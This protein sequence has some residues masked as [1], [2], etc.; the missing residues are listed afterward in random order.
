MT[1]RSTLDS[2]QLSG[3]PRRKSFRADQFVWWVT[4]PEHTEGPRN[5]IGIIAKKWT[6]SNGLTK[7]TRP[8]SSAEKKDKQCDRLHGMSTHRHYQTS[9]L[10]DHPS[11]THSS[12]FRVLLELKQ[13]GAPQWQAENVFFRKFFLYFCISAIACIVQYL[14]GKHHE[15]KQKQKKNSSVID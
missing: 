8:P 6:N 10:W 12:Y 2:C 1:D 14:Y 9:T 3:S 5:Q 7:N 15:K 4:S 13:R 11:H